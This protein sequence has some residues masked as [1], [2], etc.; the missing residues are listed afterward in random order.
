MTYQMLFYC[1]EQIVFEEIKSTHFFYILFIVAI[2]EVPITLSLNFIQNSW[3]TKYNR[4]F[5]LIHPF[6]DTL[7]S[8]KILI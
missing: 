1:L 3:F 6:P 2:S 8:Q 4:I 7:K 5:H